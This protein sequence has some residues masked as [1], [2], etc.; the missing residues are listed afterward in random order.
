MSEDKPELTIACLA[1]LHID[2]GI[3][4]H[5]HP[6]REG[7]IKVCQQ[8]AKDEN[9]DVLLVGGDTV[10]SNN[11]SNW[12]YKTFCHVRNTIHKDLQSATKTNRILYAKLKYELRFYFL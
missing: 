2:Y 4:K 12:K 7:T 11:L 9:V 10:S 6:N 5:K 1:D 3:H 8:L